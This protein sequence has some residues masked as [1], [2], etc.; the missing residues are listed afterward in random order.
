MTDFARRFASA[1]GVFAFGVAG[2][3][4][5]ISGVAVFTALWRGLIAGFIFFLIG[6]LLAVALL[7]DPDSLP[8]S[9]P[10]DTFQSHERQS[11]ETGEKKEGS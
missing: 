8:G 7:Y 2:F 3:M 9:I 6:K 5:M 10:K 4:A 11:P 1:L